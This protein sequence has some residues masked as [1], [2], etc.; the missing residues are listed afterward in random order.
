M[1]KSTLFLAV[2]GI[3]FVGCATE[4][5]I[6]REPQQVGG[7][8]GMKHINVEALSLKNAGEGMKISFRGKEALSLY[9]TLPVSILSENPEEAAGFIARGKTHS[10]IVRCVSKRYDG[11]RKNYVA[12]HDAPLCTV[13]VE[14]AKPQ[15]DLMQNKWV[16][17]VQQ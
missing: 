13:T 17:P 4:K 11:T 16:F 9:N 10:V 12:I 6:P 8:V 2:L 7:D 3:A 14:K 1:K 5:L 15:A